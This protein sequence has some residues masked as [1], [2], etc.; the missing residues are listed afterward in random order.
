MNM[1]YIVP[2]LAIALSAGVIYTT[3]VKAATPTDWRTSFVNSLAE[4]LGVS[5]DKVDSAVTDLRSERRVEMQNRYQ[6]RLDELVTLGKITST[7]KEAILAKK[8]EL[9]KEWESEEIKREEHRAEL[10]SWATENG[11]DLS[12]IGPMGLGG[13]MGE[14]RGMGM[15]G[16]W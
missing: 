12:V 5:N 9:Q 13:G 11:I 3:S 7:Q 10:T 2:A 1:K 15:R 8:A 14:G 16:D 4:K 6:E